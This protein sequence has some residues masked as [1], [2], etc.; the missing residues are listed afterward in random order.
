MFPSNQSGIG[1]NSSFGLVPLAGRGG[2]SSTDE[3]RSLVRILDI[4]VV[5]CLVKRLPQVFSNTVY[6]K[7]HLNSTENPTLIERRRYKR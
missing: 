2:T 7:E 3:T 5:S 6:Y 4:V 1:I